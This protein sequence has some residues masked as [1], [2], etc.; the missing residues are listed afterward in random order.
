MK[1][2]KCQNCGQVLYFE[3]THCEQCGHQLGFLPPAMTLSALEPDGDLWRPL[4]AAEA[5]ASIL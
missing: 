1:L 3:N 2:F 4:A 5:S